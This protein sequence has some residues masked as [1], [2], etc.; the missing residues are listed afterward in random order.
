MKRQERGG[1]EKEKEDDVEENYWNVK[2]GRNLFS[3]D[4]ARS[5]AVGVTKEELEAVCAKWCRVLDDGS[6]QWD[7]TKLK[8]L[9][10]P[11]E[12]N[13]LLLVRNL[14]HGTIV[15]A[16]VYPLIFETSSEE[17]NEMV[18]LRSLSFFNQLLAD[19][20][21]G[22]SRY[23][24]LSDEQKLIV[25]VGVRDLFL[26][27][28]HGLLNEQEKH[29]LDGMVKMLDETVGCFEAMGMNISFCPSANFKVVKFIEALD[30]T[31]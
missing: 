23:Q 4:S 31:V 16:Q 6:Y 28:W 12:C 14:V 7:L 19:A 10:S 26:G 17:D 11:D 9:L 3:I 20:E 24:S 2:Q 22:V 13:D 15:S 29:I 1:E 18:Q 8:C 25:A 27:A 5:P 30:D 21:N